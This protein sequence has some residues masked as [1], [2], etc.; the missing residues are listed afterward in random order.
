MSRL[1]VRER[2]HVGKGAGVPR[3][4]ILAVE[5]ADLKVYHTHIR[6][7]ELEKLAAD[8]EAQIIYLPKGEGEGE[9]G[10]K[11]KSGGGR[12]RRRGRADEQD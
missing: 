1:F 10:E 6:K 4:E 7:A 3:F 8:I 12:R 5:G 2:Q 9:Q 11:P